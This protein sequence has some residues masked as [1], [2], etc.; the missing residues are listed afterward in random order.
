MRKFGKESTAPTEGVNRES[1]GWLQNH[2][3]LAVCIIALLAF[4]LRTAFAYGVS[5]DGNFALSGGSEAQYHLHVVESILNGSF[6]IGADAAAN[7]PIGG[8]NLNPPLY[9][10]IAAGIGSIGGAS[11]A[12]AV[13]APIFGALTVFPVYLVGKELR[14]VKVGVLAAL[15]YALLALPISAS[16]FSNGTEFAFAAFLFAFF[17]LMMI[18]LIKKVDEDVLAVKEAVIA[19][20]FLGLIALTWNGFRMI[21]VLLIIVMVIQIVLDRFNSKDFKVPLYSYSIVMVIGVV[22]GALYYIPAGL[23]DA[24]FSGPVLI[25]VTA[26]VFGFIFRAVASKPWIFTIPALIIAFAAVAV[27]LFFVD[28]DLCT[29]LLVGNSSYTNPIMQ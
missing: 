9:D 22:M 12:L 10:F 1:G 6:V 3:A 11:F 18:K 27:V 7:Y 29:A 4:V 23:W 25:T 17:I 15:I 21:L 24:V 8:L 26:V 19:G 2:G 5:A 16:V 20:V 14:S 13:L 28:S